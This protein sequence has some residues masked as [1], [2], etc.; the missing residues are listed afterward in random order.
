MDTSIINN[1]SENRVMVNEPTIQENCDALCEFVSTDN[2][3]DSKFDSL[4]TAIKARLCQSPEGQALT[5]QLEGK[6]QRL[7]SRE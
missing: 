1:P 6:L 5:L 2:P 7:R 4:Q 3:A